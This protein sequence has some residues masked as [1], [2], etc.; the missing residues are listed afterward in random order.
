MLCQVKYPELSH[1]SL[2]SKDVTTKRMWHVK[3]ILDPNEVQCL[4]KQNRNDKQNS[5]V[6]QKFKQVTNAEPPAKCHWVTTPN[7]IPSDSHV[8]A[9]NSL[10]VM[11]APLTP[12]T[13]HSDSKD[14]TTKVIGIQVSSYL[15]TIKWS[16]KYIVIW[17]TD[18]PQVA[19]LNVDYLEDHGF[20]QL[21]H[22]SIHD[23]KECTKDHTYPKVEG[24]IEEFIL[25]LPYTGAADYPIDAKVHPDNFLLNGHNNIK[26]NWDMEVV[27]LLERDLL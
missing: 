26:A 27:T 25:D 23:V 10:T 21:M 2:K 15:E 3:K 17:G 7:I 13:P 19:T 8:L 24:T 5:Y 20:S 22:V 18:K 16:S 6:N 14:L 11:A 1:L 9:S 4:R 12:L